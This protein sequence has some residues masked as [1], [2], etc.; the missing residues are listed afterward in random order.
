DQVAGS[1]V[2][3]VKGVSAAGGYPLTA[4]EVVEDHLSIS[5][6][7]SAGAETPAF[8][9]VSC[10]DFFQDL[11]ALIDLFTRDIQRGADANRIP[12]ARQKEQPAT[13]SLLNNAIPFCIGPLFRLVIAN[14]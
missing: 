6:A 11:Q 3:T 2:Q 10:Q 14:Q 13:E 8:P 7:R 12:S 9:D 4:N 5:P 1:R